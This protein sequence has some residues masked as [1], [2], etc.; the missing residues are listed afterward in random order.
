MK[1]HIK[2][3]QKTGTEIIKIYQPRYLWKET[4]AVNARNRV[5]GKIS[6][7]K[8]DPF[9]DKDGVLRVAG[10]LLKSNLS[11]ELKHPILVHKYC[12]ISQLIIRC[13]HEKT[14]YSGRE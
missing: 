1:N 5:P 9:F 2:I 3:F 13:Y 12:T 7:H 8:L 10:R 4:E 14:V 6:T 11:H